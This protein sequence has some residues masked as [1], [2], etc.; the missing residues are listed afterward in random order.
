MGEQEQLGKVKKEVHSRTGRW[1]SGVGK[2]TTKILLHFLDR[3]GNS[4][5][6][7]LS[8]VTATIL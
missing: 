3:A 5:M 4:S 8:N 6:L 1:A 2:G 7:M